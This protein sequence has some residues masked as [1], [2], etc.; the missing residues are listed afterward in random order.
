MWP[1]DQKNGGNHQL[2]KLSLKI[3]QDKYFAYKALQI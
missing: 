1:L 2:E 3:I